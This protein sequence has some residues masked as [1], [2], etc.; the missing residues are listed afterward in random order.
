MKIRPRYQT[1]VDIA[2]EIVK[3]LRQT[4]KDEISLVPYAIGSTA[5]VNKAYQEQV[6]D[7]LYS[8]GNMLRGI[9]SDLRKADIIEE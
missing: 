1:S 6:A 5:A 2:A 7:I 3:V 9:E 8:V 4:L